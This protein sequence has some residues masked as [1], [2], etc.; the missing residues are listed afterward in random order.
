MVALKD[1]DLRAILGDD[2]RA[3]QDAFDQASGLDATERAAL[4]RI[5]NLES[6]KGPVLCSVFLGVL[7]VIATKYS[8]TPTAATIQTYIGSGLVIGGLAIFFWIRQQVSRGATGPAI[9]S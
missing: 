6:R 5:D 2:Y 8:A 3:K 7:L 4:A 1:A 9:G